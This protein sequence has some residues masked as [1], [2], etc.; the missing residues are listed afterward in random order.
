MAMKRDTAAEAS[1]SELAGA[2]RASRGVFWHAGGFS[3]FVNLL[4]L[5]GPLYMLQV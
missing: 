5:A 3:L 1:S 2:L 4:M